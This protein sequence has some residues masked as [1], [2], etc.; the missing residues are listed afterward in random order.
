MKNTIDKISEQIAA[1]QTDAALQ[2]D[3]GN[4]A[5]GARARKTSLKLTEL[6]KEF[7]KISVAAKVVI[8]IAA[9]FVSCK[10]TGDYEPGYGSL[11]V[12]ALSDPTVID[13]DSQ[14]ANAANTTRA[15]NLDTKTYHLTLRSATAT[16]YDGT[17]PEDGTLENIPAGAYT[18][19][20]SANK[21]EIP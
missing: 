6:L 19:T 17:M 11:Q 15:A 20:L 4:K 14:S 5:A 12:T 10:R 2:I 1:F 9:L 16:A 7:R 13:I 8:L 21:R 3:K 18:A